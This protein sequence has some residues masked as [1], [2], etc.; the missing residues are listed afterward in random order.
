MAVREDPYGAFNFL[1]SLGD[2]DE[3]SAAAGFSDVSGLGTE[4]DY[5]EYRNGNDRTNHVRRI[6]GLHKAGDVTLKRGVVGDARLFDWLKETREGVIGPR[7]VVVTLLDEQRQAVCRWVLR[8]AQP[9]RWSG[10]ALHAKG[11][12]E[13]AMEELQLVVD[14]VDLDPV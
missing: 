9:R 12:G 10:P 8:G 5:V 13:V 14:Q 1:V 2:G 11:G 6:P 7:T 3:T 4:I